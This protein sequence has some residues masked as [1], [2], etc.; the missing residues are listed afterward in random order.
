LSRKLELDS[1]RSGAAERV[2]RYVIEEVRA[3]SPY[4]WRQARRSE[5]AARAGAFQA[6]ELAP[7]LGTFQNFRVARVSELAHTGLMLIE[8]GFPVLVGEKPLLPDN[9]LALQARGARCVTLLPPGEP[10]P[11]PHGDRLD[12]VL[13]DLCHLAKFADAEHYAGQ[14]GLFATLA[15]AFADPRWHE[16]ERQLD[17]A[18]LADRAAVSADMNGSC[19]FLLAVLKMRLKMAA[20]RRLA[21]RRG[22]PAPTSGAASPDEEREFERVFGA[23]LDALGL[24]EDVRRAAVATNAR[25][26]DPEGARRLQAHFEAR[27]RAELLTGERRDDRRG[28]T[29]APVRLELER[30]ACAGEQSDA[31]GEV[32][33][34]AP[35]Q[36]FHH[37]GDLGRAVRRDGDRDLERQ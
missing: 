13:H 4:T 16:V 12:F 35:G 24:S 9:L 7:C 6:N 27:G 3:R 19:V 14:V 26:D 30:S 22:V 10:V 25:R 18:W 29:N 34:G 2:A 32:L 36:G 31:H 5:P 23:L 20:R 21:A 1:A 33:D 28:G 11:E 15:R 17:A 8:R 37:L